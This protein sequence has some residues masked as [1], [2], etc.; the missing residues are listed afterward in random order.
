M[1]SLTCVSCIHE[2]ACDRAWNCAND[3]MPI[4]PCPHRKI[5]PCP[6]GWKVE[7]REDVNRPMRWWSA[8]LIPPDDTCEENIGYDC[9]SVD[10]AK[11]SPMVK[12]LV[13]DLNAEV[14]VVPI[15]ETK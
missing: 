13:R 3:R 8:C 6:S 5:A 9:H 7:I 11:N 12:A 1:T 10:E 15:E 2:K 4:L 14:V